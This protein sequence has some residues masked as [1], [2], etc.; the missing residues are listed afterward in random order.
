LPGLSQ[1]TKL[2]VLLSW[3][4]GYEI[5]HLDRTLAWTLDSGEEE[6]L[7]LDG[8]S[9]T[10]LLSSIAVS[11]EKQPPF[12]LSTLN[13]SIAD[14]VAPA[15]VLEPAWLAR[16]YVELG[17][18]PEAFFDLMAEKV[19]YDDQSEMHA[20]KMQQAAYD[21]FYATRN[22]LRSVHLIAAAK[23]A[24]IVS[25]LGPRTVYPSALALTAA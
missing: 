25:R 11:I 6:P 23:H 1:R 18:D 14:L 7:K 20:Y 10:D 21:E 24:A 9:Q 8:K 16:C 4:Q 12:D 22:E 2:L 3:G 13:G 15:S 17:H 5:R 19:C